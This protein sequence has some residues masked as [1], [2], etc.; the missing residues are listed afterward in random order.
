MT[1]G[2][3][4]TVLGAIGLIP[5]WRSGLRENMNFYEFILE[6]T[7]LSPHEVT[8]VP[9]EYLTRGETNGI[10]MRIS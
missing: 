7:I 6:H 10:Y 1:R 5:V 3:W 4:L 8:Y 9:E 2:G